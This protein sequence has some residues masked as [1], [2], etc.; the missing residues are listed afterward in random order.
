MQISELEA[1]IVYRVSSKTA[2]DTQRNPVSKKQTTTS[3]KTATKKKQKNDIT[4]NCCQHRNQSGYKDMCK[5]LKHL[6]L[7]LKIRKTLWGLE[8]WLSGLEY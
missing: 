8:R 6:P 5:V 2:R 1:S 7:S 4:H 3:A